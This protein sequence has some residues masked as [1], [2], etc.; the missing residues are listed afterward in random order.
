MTT[1]FFFLY[2]K[3]NDNIIKKKLTNHHLSLF[4][5]ETGGIVVLVRI[6]YLQEKKIYASNI[7]NECINSGDDI[8]IR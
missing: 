7:F 1:L 6:M 4:M 5:N 3:N 8:F 2:Y